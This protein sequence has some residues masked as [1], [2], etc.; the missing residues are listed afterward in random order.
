MVKSKTEARRLVSKHFYKWIQ[1]FGK[2]AS[3]RMPT[4]KLRDYV[5]KI[6]K[7][8]ILRKRKVYLLLRKERDKM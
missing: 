6:K 2:N 4:K 7:G 8:F 3:K 1:I 5:I